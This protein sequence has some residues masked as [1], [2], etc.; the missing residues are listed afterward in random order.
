MTRF[1]D[2]NP[3]IL[4]SSL[5]IAMLAE[6][7]R[8]MRTVVLAGAVRKVVGRSPEGR[9]SAQ[10]SCRNR[11]GSGSRRRRLRPRHPVRPL[12][13]M[14][15]LSPADTFSGALVFWR[16]REGGRADAR[17]RTGAKSSFSQTDL[18]RHLTDFCVPASLGQRSTQRWRSDGA[19]RA[20]SRGHP[21]QHAPEGRLDLRRWLIRRC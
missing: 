1:R 17:R 20:G 12:H 3:T 14:T 8:P 13:D 11:A 19:K 9:R 7:G 16:Q 18:S 15:I 4:P 5:V 10:G 6:H 2:Y 21:V